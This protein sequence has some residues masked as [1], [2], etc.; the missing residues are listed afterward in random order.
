MKMFPDKQNPREFL[1]I[2]AAL[3]EMLKE[4]C[5]QKKKNIRQ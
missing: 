4:Y 2:R 3:Q 5:G 1:A